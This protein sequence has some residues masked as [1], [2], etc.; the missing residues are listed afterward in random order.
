MPSGNYVANSEGEAGMG[1]QD[2]TRI[3]EESFH[4]QVVAGILPNDGIQETRVLKVDAR[5][6]EQVVGFRYK[7]FEEQVRSVV[8]H[9]LELKGV[10]FH[11]PVWHV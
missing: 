11:L 8:E 5:R 4:E 10:K 1:W 7:S 9:Y 2:L 3:V 6:T